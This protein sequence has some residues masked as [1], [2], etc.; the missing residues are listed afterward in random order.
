MNARHLVWAAA[1]ISLSGAAH[2]AGNYAE[3]DLN[4]TT[5]DNDFGGGVDDQSQGIGVAAR[6]RLFIEGDYFV[7]GDAE[8]HFTDGATGGANYD[9]DSQLYRL[10]LG[11]Q[12]YAG[13]R[14]LLAAFWVEVV[15][16]RIDRAAR[17]GNA[18]TDDIGG[19]VQLRFDR[20]SR[21]GRFLP[22]LQLGY[23]STDDFDGAEAR[24]GSRLNL[25]P[26]Q[27]YAEVRYLDREGSDGGF[28]QVS[29][30]AG[31]RLTF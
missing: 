18:D 19:A 3:F 22:Y 8:A 5:S 29:F 28:E 30:A 12:D 31:V 16:S 15:Y 10:G 14:D 27:P 13:S 6:G 11:A 2:S 20:A 25:S 24:L 7:Q 26:V 17:S 9:L 23:V 4:G 21:E 1:L